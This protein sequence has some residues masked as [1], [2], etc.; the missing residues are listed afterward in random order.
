M[1]NQQNQEYDQELDR[2]IQEFDRKIVHLLWTIFLSAITAI[3]TTLLLCR[4][5]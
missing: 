4:V 1:R 3:V 5:L 2:R